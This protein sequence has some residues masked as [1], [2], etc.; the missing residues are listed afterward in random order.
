[1]RK[2][3]LLSGF[4]LGMA[5]ESQAQVLQFFT[6]DGANRRI[7]ATEVDSLRYNCQEGVTTLYFFDGKEESFPIEETDSVVWYEPSNSIFYKLQSKGNY[8]CFLR[9]VQESELWTDQMNGATD[10]TVFAAN[11]DGWQRFFAGNAMLP[12][13]DPWHTA[14]SYEAL[15]EEQKRVLLAA[16][17]TSPLKMAE[18]SG[19]GG[20]DERLR[21][22]DVTGLAEVWTPILTPAFCDRNTITETDQSIICGSILTAPWL[23][24]NSFVETDIACGN[25]WLEQIT[26]PLKPLSTM[27]DVIRTNG[28]TNIFAHMMDNVLGQQ[29]EYGQILK[30]DPG[31]AGF[32][33]YNAPEKDMAAM[34]VPSD[35]TLWSYF[36]EGAGQAL[37][38]VYYA[39]EGTAEAIP[40]TKP[41]TQDEL[42]SQIDCLPVNIIAIP[43]NT[44]MMRSFIGSV[45]TKWTKLRDDA[46]QPLFD[47]IDDGLSN[48]DTC[49]IASNGAVYVFD[50]VFAPTDFRS[51]TAPVY[52][53]N[54]S[55][56]IKSAI[57][58]D[59]MILNYYAYLKA[60]QQDITFFLPTDE[61]LSYYYD[62]ISMKSRTPRTIKFSFVGGNFPVKLQLYNYF[63]PYNQDKGEIGT[64]G[65]MIPGTRLYT[66]SEVTDRLKDILY[67]H[68]I[69]NDGTQNIHSR[70][71]YYRTYGGDVVKVVR[72]ASGKIVGA[73]GTFQ[74]ENERQNIVS[75]TP[76]VTECTVTDSYES[77]SNGQTYAL[78]APLVPTYR[79][80]WSMMTND[81]DMRDKE[82]FGGETPYSEFYKLCAADAYQEVI[83]GCGLVDGYLPSA[84][85]QAALKKYMTFIS[86]NGLDYNFAQLAGNTP[87]TAYIPTNE[88]VKAAIA[89]GLPTWE[90]ISEDYNSHSSDGILTTFEDSIRITEK[91]MILTDVVKAHFHYGMAIADQ[92]PFQREYKSIWVDRDTMTSPKLKVNC[93]GN[94]KMT[95][96]DWKGHTFN[97]TNN[98]NVFVRDYS[99]NSSPV[100]VKMTGIVM[101]AYRSGVVHQIDGVLG[102]TK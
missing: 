18:E 47:N 9:L 101:N 86:D 95:V 76:G 96:T 10:L 17:I 70:N 44:G 89:Q 27:A 8:T 21:V 26:V 93:T 45:P 80:L 88:A 84:K 69:V 87:Y 37:L 5:V 60:P 99:C 36:T 98:K 3:A 59:Y 83:I 78:D 55:R 85:R 2:L 12:S 15:T 34:L 23:A 58:N 57:Y 49:L 52:M 73:K 74:L 29:F 64:I 56:I 81:A 67:S 75:E 50:E 7:D 77:L 14:T 1:M 94:G 48:L 38:H 63:C 79:S 16:A 72:D 32:Y 102:F 53:S 82:G 100:N 6:K 51:V 90:E 92:E 35:K 25:G 61:A 11:D 97:I 40:Y 24:E 66:N 65:N 41:A 33:E 30:F 39:K 13:S 28:Q 42:F 54:S 4:L 20:S 19:I 31:W 43:I 46:M 68:T 91:I 62:P 71:E 22:H